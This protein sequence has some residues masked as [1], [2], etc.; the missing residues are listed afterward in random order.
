MLFWCCVIIFYMDIPRQPGF[1]WLS[2]HPEETKQLLSAVVK[3]I[4][5][6]GFKSKDYNWKE[7]IKKRTS[8]DYRHPI[9][10]PFGESE[11]LANREFQRF[12]AEHV[13]GHEGWDEV[14][15]TFQVAN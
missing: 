9:A 3:D 13:L 4:K 10:E 6:Q 1:S 12:T 15:E 14:L 8:T 5:L 7:E 11:I 2:R